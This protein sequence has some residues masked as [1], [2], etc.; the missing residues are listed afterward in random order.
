MAAWWPCGIAGQEPDIGVI[1]RADGLTLSQAPILYRPS[2]TNAGSA[3][4]GWRPV[5][6]TTIMC[7][8]GASSASAGAQHCVHYSV[9]ILLLPSP[10]MQVH[11]SLT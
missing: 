2:G 8:N 6:L 9:L 11:V 10:G 4:C 7:S 3:M 5:H 1:L